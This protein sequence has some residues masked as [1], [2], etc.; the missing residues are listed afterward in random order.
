[1]I[2]NVPGST[3]RCMSTSIMEKRIRSQSE[4]DGRLLSR[5]QGHTLEAAQLFT[6]RVTEATH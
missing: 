1:M 6:G 3:T 4:F 5:L 2:A